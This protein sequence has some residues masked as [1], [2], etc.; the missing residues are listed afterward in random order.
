MK[1]ILIFIGGAGLL[2]Y[3][4]YRYFSVQSALLKD[5]KYKILSVKVG[6]VSNREISFDV[7][8]RFISDSSI[9]ATIKKIYLDV[10]VEGMNVGYISNENEFYIPAKGFSDMSLSFSFNPQ[11]LLKGVISLTL[12]AVQKKDISFA[13]KGAANVSS[14]FIS[15]TVPVN[16]ETTIK[17]YLST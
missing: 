11:V 16:Y 5:F 6:R 7:K 8:I 17:E 10:F 12:S 9:S 1:K 4:L 2:G 15:V 3:A 14:G 13:L